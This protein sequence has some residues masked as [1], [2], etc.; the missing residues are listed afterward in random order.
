IHSLFFPPLTGAPK[1]VI[2]DKLVEDTESAWGPDE[3]AE[4]LKTL[5]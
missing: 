1:N 5:K 4:K 2:D 3:W